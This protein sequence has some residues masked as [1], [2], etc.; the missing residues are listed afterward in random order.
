M[1]L[2]WGDEKT[3]QFVTNVGL[4]TTNG[5]YEHNIMAAEWTHQV[6]YKPGLIAVCIGPNKATLENIRESKE[7]GVS[8]AAADQNVLSSVAGGSSGKGY[9][10]VAALKEIGFKF[11]NAKKIKTLLLEGAVLNLECKLFKEI[12]L[13]DH[14]MFVGEVVEASLNKDK[15]PLAYHKIKYWKLGESIPKPPQQELEKIKSIVE[16]HKK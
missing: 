14:V 15:E 4:I 11:Y 10:K 13:G 3:V 7:F 8:L 1:D 16:K 5:P 12:Q 6:S 2:Q 9:D